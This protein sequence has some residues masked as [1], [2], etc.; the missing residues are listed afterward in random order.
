MFT[1]SIFNRDCCFIY[2]ILLVRDFGST[3]VVFK[4]ALEINFDL[5]YWIVSLSLFSLFFLCRNPGFWSESKTRVFMLWVNTDN[6]RAPD[7]KVSQSA[8]KLSNIR[9]PEVLGNYNWKWHDDANGVLLFL[10]QQCFPLNETGGYCQRGWE[11]LYV[12]SFQ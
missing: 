1:C 8:L 2:I 9:Q 4:C 6:Y 7:G 11:T 3:E 12:T 10:L 5:T